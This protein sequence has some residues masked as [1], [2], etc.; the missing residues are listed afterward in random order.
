MGNQQSAPK[1]VGEGH[2]REKEKRV[3]RRVSVQALPHGKANA[4]DPSAS[5]AS[6]TAQNIP[7]YV[8]KPALQQHLH[9]SQSPELRTKMQG[10][11]ER[12]SSRGSAKSEKKE[13]DSQHRSRD[14][15]ESAPPPAGPMDVPSAPRNKHEDFMDPPA[16]FQSHYTPV[17]KLRPPRLPLPIADA[18]IP[19][20]PT[21]APVQTG[22]EDVSIFEEDAA[23]DAEEPELRRKSSMLSSTTQ[24]D[25]EMGDELQPYA[26]DTRVTKAVH[27]KIEWRHSGEKVYVTGTFANWDRKF[28]LHRKYVQIHLFVLSFGFRQPTISTPLLFRCHLS[29]QPHCRGMSRAFLFRLRQ[30]FDCLSHRDYIANTGPQLVVRAERDYLQQ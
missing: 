4:V 12:S 26:V 9:A 24:D 3:N 2:L 20:S 25:E 19:E 6:A 5:N 8:E 18:P 22:N 16:H 29:V 23:N 17:S 1:T 27:T 7:Q 15:H 30:L 28:R 11:L 10:G 21:L 13:K 14:R